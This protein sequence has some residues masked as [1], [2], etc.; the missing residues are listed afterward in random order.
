MFFGEIPI[1]KPTPVNVLSTSIVSVTCRAMASSFAASW[2]FRNQA[3]VG[4][5]SFLSI[6]KHV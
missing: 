6:N 2:K 4:S 3:R 5:I 1:H